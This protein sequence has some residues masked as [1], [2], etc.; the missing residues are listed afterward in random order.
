[1]ALKE[2]FEIL[3]GEPI[4][5]FD[6]DPMDIPCIETSDTEKLCKHPV[7][8]VHMITYNHE[9]YIRQAIEGVL[10]QKTDFE[11]ELLIGEDASQDKTREICFEYQKKYPDKIRV[12][13][14]HEN[15]S[16]L[17]GNSRR[18]MARCRGEFIAFCEG[19]DYWTDPLKLQKQ[20]GIMRDNQKVSLCF[21]RAKVL[22]QCTG[23]MMQE[24]AKGFPEGMMSGK[25]FSKRRLFEFLKDLHAPSIPNPLTRTLTAVVRKSILQSM[26]DRFHEI[27]A[28]AL[29][30]GDTTIWFGSSFFGDIYFMTDEVAVYRMHSG[31]VTSRNPGGLLRDGT[32]VRIFYAMRLWGLSYQ[33][34]LAIYRDMLFNGWINQAEKLPSNSQKKLAKNMGA[35][36]SLV[37]ARGFRYKV[38]LVFLKYGFFTKWTK[39]LCD[40]IFYHCQNECQYLDS[41]LAD[42][43]TKF[44]WKGEHTTQDV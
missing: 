28:M 8:S 12:L 22:D 7:I 26:Q 16:K 20:V 10:S 38:Y 9:P 27:F 23:N 4:S 42:V 24:S 17:G 37:R 21:G 44:I 19:D 40:F 2:D 43:E 34:C 18:V 11:F 30:L 1:M 5:V 15:V 29:R 3:R 31:G 25:E 6:G 35:F 14:W 39:V 41:A 33:V 13:W 32:L 36:I